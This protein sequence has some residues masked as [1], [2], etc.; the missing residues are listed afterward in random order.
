MMRV[1]TKGAVSERGFT[2]IEI[3]IVVAI[4]VLLAGLTIATILGMQHSDDISRGAQQIY[5][6]LI[7]IRSR[8]ITMNTNHRINFLSTSQWRLEAYNSTTTN[9]DV[10]SD[11]R[12]MPLNTYLT[13]ES[14]NN[15]LTNLNATP[16]GL[17]NFLNGKSG[18]P[19]VTIMAMGTSNVKLVNVYVGGA[20]EIKNP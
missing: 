17:F 2:M 4:I 14:Y 13:N 5:D 19:F 16:R 6:D 11:L 7:T 10:V 12:R 18:E 3:L 20:V 1:R 15:A 9:W 8:A